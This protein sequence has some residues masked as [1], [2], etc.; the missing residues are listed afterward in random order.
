MLEK[1]NQMYNAQMYKGNVLTFNEGHIYKIAG[2][3]LSF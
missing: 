3:V 1:S 2:S